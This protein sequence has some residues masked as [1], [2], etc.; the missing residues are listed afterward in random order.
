MAPRD[1]QKARNILC[2]RLDSMGDVL[3]TSPAM[4]ALKLARRGRKITLLTSPSGASV[5]H[6]IP[7]IDDVLVYEAPWMKAAQPRNDSS[8]DQNMVRILEQHRF[9]AAVIF[10]VFSQSPLPAALLAYLANIPLRLA[11]CRENPYHL[12]TDWV[13]ETEPEGFP[14][15]E[16]RRQLDLV[17]TLGCNLV[18]ERM[19]IQ[20]PRPLRKSVELKLRQVLP[21]QPIPWVV[22]HP[23]ASAPSRRYAPEGFASVIRSLYTRHGLLSVLTGGEAEVPLIER[24]RDLSKVPTVS[25]AGELAVGEL[26]ALLEKAT[27][28]ISNN[29]GPAHL[30]AAVGTPVVDLYALTNPQHT[31]WGVPNRVLFHDVKC[32]FCYKSICPVGHHNCLRL[33][34]PE[35]VIAAVCDLLQEISRQEL[36]VQTAPNQ[37]MV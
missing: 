36:T 3:M 9:D 35:M 29:T 33:V 12:L 18:D 14:R 24:I 10:T 17:S 23:G 25:L 11:Y 1:W 32:R 20:V 31:P 30:A 5:A 28:L 21:S 22:V 16:V 19:L 37:E 8:D 26:A 27:L 4:R 34:K 15:H 2:I 6:L 7:E 13:P